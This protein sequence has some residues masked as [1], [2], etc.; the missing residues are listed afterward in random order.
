MLEKVIRVCELTGRVTTVAT[1][2]TTEA[3]KALVIARTRED[4]DF[5]HYIR[6]V[7]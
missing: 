3:A 1:N 2:L 6:I 5:A 7:G 4:G